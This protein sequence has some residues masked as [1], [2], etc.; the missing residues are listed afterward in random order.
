MDKYFIIDECIKSINKDDEN[1]EKRLKIYSNR[2][3]RRENGEIVKPIDNYKIMGWS[4][5]K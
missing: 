4:K 2:K 3:K 1:Y 5:V